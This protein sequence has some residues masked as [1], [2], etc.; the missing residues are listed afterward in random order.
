M[1]RRPA[2]RKQPI[3]M[4]DDLCSALAGNE[5]VSEASLGLGRVAP[6]GQA[7]SVRLSHFR[8]SP[9]QFLPSMHSGEREWSTTDDVV[10]RIRFVVGSQAL[11]MRVAERAPRKPASQSGV[12]QKKCPQFRA[13][14][15]V[16]GGRWE[17]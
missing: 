10:G 17:E 5:H 12:C 6:H 3:N 7:S 15:Q 8:S 11:P 2:A 1:C 14:T 4:P 13:E 9:S 16:Q